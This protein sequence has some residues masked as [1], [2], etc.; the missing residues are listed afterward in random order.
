MSPTLLVQHIVTYASGSDS[1][2]VPGWNFT[3]DSLTESDDNDNN[4]D[5]DDNDDD[6]STTHQEVRSLSSLSPD[7]SPRLMGKLMTSE[8][9]PVE[10]PDT[11]EPENDFGFTPKNKVKKGKVASKRAMFDF[12]SNYQG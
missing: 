8:P 11:P 3:E 6:T 5:N 2:L 12:D 7:A 10:V 4:D 9:V 1:T